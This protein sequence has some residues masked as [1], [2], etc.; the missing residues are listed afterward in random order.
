MSSAKRK[1]VGYEINKERIKEANRGVTNVVFKKADITKLSIP[2]SD[3]VI[4]FHVLHHLRSFKVQE[5]L[6][7]K[8]Y[9]SLSKNGKLIIVEVNVNYSI[10][11]FVAW[12]FDHFIVPIVFERKLYDEIYFRRKENWKEILRK[13]G[14]S[15]EIKEENKG[16]IFPHLILCCTKTHN[17]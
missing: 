12:T 11:F 16:M 1:V 6:L 15:V 13:K 3:A 14:F 17:L 7:S 5:E 8:I 2:K 10:K 9:K 4:L